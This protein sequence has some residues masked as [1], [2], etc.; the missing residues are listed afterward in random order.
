M[1]FDYEVIRTYAY[2]KS[3]SILIKNNSM[4][5]I[6]WSNAITLPFVFFTEMHRIMAIAL[7]SA[8]ILTCLAS[9]LAMIFTKYN[10]P[11]S[12]LF[13][14]I[15]SFGLSLGHLFGIMYLIYY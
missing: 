15:T 2:D 5:F 4:G 13:F 8:D 1:D 3:S 9:A 6:I 7:I 14:G 11:Y 12:I 10:K